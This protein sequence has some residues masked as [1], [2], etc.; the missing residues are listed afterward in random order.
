M[1]LK[2][3]NPLVGPDLLSVSRAMGHGDEIAI[4]DANYP[5]EAHAE[6]CLRADGHSVTIMLEA[7]LSVLPL[8][9]LVAAAAFRPVPPD[10]AGHKVHREFDAIVAKYEPGLPVVPL[11]GD[12]FYERVKSAYA[13]IATGER[14]FYGNI[15]LR[16]G[17]IDEDIE[18]ML[19]RSQITTQCHDIGKV[20]V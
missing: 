15:I 14:R 7:L 12:A 1:M 16:K 6:R 8:D 10:A 20:A 19:E 3:I 9:R 18:P 13:I 2:G 17:V 4:V 11:S 5:A